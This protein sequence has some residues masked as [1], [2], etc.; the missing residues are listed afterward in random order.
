MKFSVV[1]IT[2]LAVFGT[3]Q[4]QSVPILSR[5]L[6]QDVQDFLSLI[7]VEEITELFFEYLAN[8]EDFG[9]AMDYILSDEFKSLIISVE[10]MP[11]VQNLL[12]YLEDA[13]LNVYELIN[14]LHHLLG[15]DPIRPRSQ[16]KITGG[17]PGF[18]EDLK[19]LLP[20]EKLQKLY[21][22]KLETSEEFATLISMLKSAEFQNLVDRVMENPELQ[23]II[24]NAESKGVD[25]Q[26][27]FDLLNTILGLKFPHR[28]SFYFTRNLKND[29]DDF[30][31][32]VPRQAIV[33]L[34]Y[35]YLSEDED[36]G[37]ALDYVLSDEF[38]Q[39]VIDVESISEVKNL[40]NFLE[41]S[42]LD[43]FEFINKIN[44]LLGIHR[45]SSVSN[46][47]VTKIT[48]GLPG[49]IEDI[50]ALL[51]LDEIDALYKKKLETS[52]D[53]AML[54]EKLMSK[55]FQGIVDQVLKNPVMQDL[56][57]RAEAKG[58]DVQ[59]IFEFITNILGIKFPSRPTL[60][61]ANNLQD[62][63]NDFLSLIP[64]EAIK[65]LFYQ[66]LAEDQDFGE[67][68]D[69]I[70][71]SEF[72]NF[73]AE[74]ENM[75]E[76][77]SLVDF[78]EESGLEA[79]KAINIINDFLG[80]D[81]IQPLYNFKFQKI[82]GGLPGF[83]I[84][85]K[86]I[87]PLKEIEEMYQLKLKT[88]ENF[89]SFVK[90]IQSKEMQEL[91]NKL[92]SNPTVQDL[93]KRTEAKGVNVQALFD[94]L[95]SLF[96][97]KFPRRSVL[98]SLGNLKDDLDDF[99]A[100]IPVK[101]IKDLF[102][103]YLSNDEDFREALDY[104]QSDE[105]KGLVMEVEG[106]QEVKG[107]LEF[108]VASGLD[109]YNFV[110]KLNDF[111]G[112]DHIT[113]IYLI[114]NRKITGG[115]PGFIEDVKAL[116]PLDK[117]ESLYNE[118][119]QTSEDFKNLITRLK[120]QEFQGLVNKFMVNPALQN[121]M[122]KAEAKGV[123]VQAILDFLTALLGIKFPPRPQRFFT[124]FQTYRN[125]EVM[126]I[127][128]TIWSMV[129]TND[130][131]D[132]V[133]D[134]LVE[135]EDFRKVVKYMLSDDFKNNLVDVEN[136]KETRDLLEFLDVTG[137]KVYEYLNLLHDILDINKKF[138]LRRSLRITGGIN[139]LFQDIWAK[140]PRDD[141]WALWNEKMATSKAWQEFVTRL[142]KVELQNLIN[143]LHEHEGY[144]DI[145]NRLENMGVD[146][147][148]V[149]RLIKTVIGIEFPKRPF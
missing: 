41:Q 119:L 64:I 121:L 85:V 10:K 83:I 100:L 136:L 138:P 34:F 143:R 123:N 68:V 58:V 79:Y 51:P 18:I 72:K 135:D 28:P 67:A 74:I 47:K 36:F 126:E 104:I 102:Y 75:P 95:T 54:M 113:P 7:P 23:K 111:L 6:Q 30:L 69:Y 52:A 32:L 57:Q 78:L 86:A 35:K 125:E 9:E 127:L 133:L 24:N 65:Q 137:V 89:A 27:I 106:S 146:F 92:M 107:F 63:F 105:F 21:K 122:K 124:T 14:K 130:I 3:H 99:L 145:L 98:L 66:Y 39:L 13:G 93:I 84:D 4:I 140:L 97:L 148:E 59:A 31:A 5:G 139:G 55:E 144:L 110:N 42:G 20:L 19:A 141:L 53:F 2:V 29:L 26:A 88:S 56:M 80:I 82:T 142:E 129:P 38:K 17:L 128:E 131:G 90:R 45:I 12:K 73:V 91:V 48:G 87:L 46:Y 134:Y 132:V 1:L 50:K 103:E 115:L 11:E 49:F 70:M 109:A 108:L 71:S 43:A 25:V 61:L 44:D 22:E 101:E 94:F 37:E 118:K 116:L 147:N 117:I 120:S 77:K 81:R 112:I 76:I 114:K 8:D 62:D 149:I 16:Y 33:D 60:M 15:I 96:G 40:L